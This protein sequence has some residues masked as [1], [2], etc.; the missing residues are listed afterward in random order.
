MSL[1]QYY[2]EMKC[3]DERQQR[4][5]QNTKRSLRNPS[6]DVGDTTRNCF[7]T[8]ASIY[9]TSLSCRCQDGSHLLPQSSQKFAFYG[10]LASI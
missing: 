3:N 1:L 2:P 10:H 9:F 7:V 5:H 6:M 4:R 8:V